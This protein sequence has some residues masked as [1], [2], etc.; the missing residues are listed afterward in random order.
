MKLK[1]IFTTLLSVVASISLV[2]G[3]SL[4]SLIPSVP[5]SPQAEAFKKYGKYAVNPSTGTPDISI[6]LYEINH[7]GYKMPL[8]LKFVPVPIRPGYNYDVFGLGW[9]LS[10]N[11]VISRS[12]E[13]LPDED[14]NFKIETPGG[15]GPASFHLCSTCLTGYNYAH[16]KFSVVLPNGSSFD[17]IIDNQNNVLVYQVSDGRQVK[18][19]CNYG[20]SEI[21][22][23]IIIDEDGVKYTFDGADYPRSDWTHVTYPGI[24]VSWNLTRIDLPNSNEP[25]LFAYGNEYL[26]KPKGYTLVEASLTVSG[27]NIYKDHDQSGNP[28]MGFFPSSQR[29]NEITP[30]AYQMRLLT[31]ITYGTSGKNRI[32][33]LYNYSSAGDSS[34]RASKIKILEDQSVKKEISFGTT[35]RSGGTF[36]PG[37]NFSL[38]TLDSVSIKGSDVNATPIKYELT[39]PSIG[40]FNGVDHWGYLTNS[41]GMDMPNFNIYVGWALDSPYTPQSG[42]APALKDNNDPCPFGK[43]IISQPLHSSGD[44]RRTGFAFAISRIKYPTGGY[45]DFGWEDHQFLSSTDNNG[46]YA[47]NPENRSIRSAPG[48]RIKTISNYSS[49]GVLTNKMNYRYGKTRGEV[50][51]SN[52]QYPFLHTGL[53]EAVADPNV[54]TYLSYSDWQVSYWQTGY[55][56]PARNM[57]IGVNH[58]GQRENFGN[59]YGYLSG[60]GTSE[61]GSVVTLSAANFRKLLNGRRPIVYSEVSVY[62][63]EIDEYS[64]IFPKGKTVYKYDLS[65]T[66][67][68]ESIE[69]MKYYGNTTGYD[70]KAFYYDRLIEKTDYKFDGQAQKFK[71]VRKEENVYTPLSVNTYLDYEFGNNFL[72]EVYSLATNP[73]G[74]DFWGGVPTSFYVS[75]TFSGKFSQQGVS[76]LVGKTI[77]DYDQSGNQLII[78]EEYSYNERAQ[79]AGKTIQTSDGKSISEDFIYPKINPLGG[80]PP[81]IADMVSKNIISPVIETSRKV[82]PGAI[83]VSASKMDFAKFGANQIIMPAKSYELEIGPSSSQYV[84]RNEIISYSANGNP[85]EFISKDGIRSAYLWEYNDRYMVAEVKNASNIDIAYTSF[86]ADGKGSWVFSGTPVADVTAPTGTKAYSLSTGN[87]TRSSLATAKSYVVSYWTKNTSALSIAGTKSGYPVKGRSVNGWTYYEHQVTGVSSVTLSGTGSFDELRLYPTDAQ[88]T[89][90]TYE[91][92]IGISAQ[93]DASGKIQYYGYDSFGRLQLIKDQDGSIVKTFEYKYKQ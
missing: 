89:T 79:L 29:F 13:S 71:P 34:Y 85:L 25:I 3:Q 84:L 15:Q 11:G 14:R 44:S 68:S 77:T 45:T 39:N 69:P 36:D 19:T 83:T 21:S 56:Y 24:F 73:S 60:Y 91:P 20:N 57:I 2:S 12:I 54:L 8:S 58:L 53:G 55:N 6:P 27:R 38:A 80:T 26:M 17:F 93:C 1:K 76:S 49:D 42:I 47:Y 48:A 51:G 74:W 75:G 63:G 72:P 59:P 46:D 90:Y 7:R 5:T 61:W 81:I 30:N 16:D 78:D 41:S 23:F 86:E 70:P 62:E 43:Y 18:I 64:G 87:I 66:L 10:I 4:Q 52:E 33:L 22:S 67:P 37:F 35:L 32:D 50:Y 40:T 9:A 31:S 88:M 92:L 65:G 28:E 82:S